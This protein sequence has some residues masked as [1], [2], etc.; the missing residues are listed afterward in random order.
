MVVVR[1]VHCM[2]FITPKYAH[3]VQLGQTGAFRSVVHKKNGATFA[4]DAAL[5]RV[6][7]YMGMGRP[8]KDANL[9]TEINLQA[10][11]RVL[12][13][14]TESSEIAEIR[15][16]MF[17]RPKPPLTEHVHLATV[18]VDQTSQGSHTNG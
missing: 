6:S 18:Y 3:S 2:F 5:F 7:I 9:K 4:D 1:H 14:R 12:P 11:V 17:L 13:V 15:T 8:L 16:D 10:D